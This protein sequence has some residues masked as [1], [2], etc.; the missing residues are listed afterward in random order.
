LH[1]EQEAHDQRLQY[2]QQRNLQQIQQEQ[3]RHRQVQV[4][5]RGEIERVRAKMVQV[6]HMAQQQVQQRK[7][8]M[9]PKPNHH[10]VIQQEHHRNQLI[11]LQVQAEIVRVRVETARVQHITQQVSQQVS[12]RNRQR[13]VSDMAPKLSICPSY[14]HEQQQEEESSTLPF[15]EPL[16]QRTWQQPGDGDVHVRRRVLA[17]T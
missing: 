9:G 12:Q 6:Q 5:V 7:S 3:H 13:K 11:Q 8:D 17:E 16:Q 4:Q 14:P 2:T 10:Q 1:K 15:L